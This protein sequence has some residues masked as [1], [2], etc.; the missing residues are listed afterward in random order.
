MLTTENK[1]SLFF[2]L[3]CVLGIVIGFVLYRFYPVIGSWCLFSIILVLAPDRKDALT[4]ATNRIKAN[5]IG[6]FIGIRISYFHPVSLP[7]I[8]IG[9]AVAMLICEWL[10]LQT[11]TKSVSE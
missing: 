5:L 3:E 11:V 10:K 2:I 6:A 1:N 9:V 7:V 8:C 4:L